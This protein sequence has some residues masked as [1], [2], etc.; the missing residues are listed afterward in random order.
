[1]FL[2]QTIYYSAVNASLT[3]KDIE[4]ILQS[5][6]KNNAAKQLS[7]I[8]AFNGQYFLQA[9]EGLRSEVCETL[10]VIAKDPRHTAIYITSHREIA[11]RDFSGWDMAYVGQSKFNRELM[12]HFSGHSD[13]VPSMLSGA[14][15]LALLKSLATHAEDIK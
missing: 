13:F 2:V 6:R 7:G 12:L 14:S 9:L 3:A 10:S 15:S 1:M 4:Q 5:S 11:E 8:L